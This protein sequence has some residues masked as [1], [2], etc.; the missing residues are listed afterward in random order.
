MLKH[1]MLAP[2]KSRR[3]LLA[4]LALIALPVTAR[5]AYQL[6]VTELT[7]V[8]AAQGTTAFTLTLNEFN[9][10]SGSSNPDRLVRTL[11]I[12]QRSDGAR[13]E[14]EVMYPGKPQEHRSR[15]IRLADFQHI[16]AMDSVGLKTTWIPWE[17]EA[18]AK[19]LSRRPTSASGCTLNEM[20]RP[21]SGKDRADSE[22]TVNGLKVVKMVGVDAPFMTRLFAPQLDC[23]EVG[24][25]AQWDG[26]HKTGGL[27]STT[28][29]VMVS[30]TL[31]EPEAGLF[32]TANLRE[33]S[34]SVAN[35][36][37]LRKAG[38]PED[39]IQRVLSELKSSETHYWATRDRAG[40]RP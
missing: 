8:R 27:A 2:F 12:A 21:A 25:L 32:L 23:E 3:F 15:T 5:F 19:R 16:R 17:R 31:G 7:I 30:Y 34:P 14:L 26:S 39:H 28:E 33:A 1:A 20:G 29:R 35:E 6:F 37:Q 10:V 11:T 24:L 40:I 9:R 36:N 38:Y 4:A 13:S 18:I 22:S